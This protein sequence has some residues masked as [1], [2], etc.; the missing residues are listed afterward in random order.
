MDLIVMNMKPN[1]HPVLLRGDCPHYRQPG[2]TLTELMV[3][4]SIIVVLALVVFG[5]ATRIISNAHKAVC[6]QNLHGIGNAIQAYC[7]ENNNRLPGPLNVG[8]SALFNPNATSP[9]PQLVHHIAPYLEGARDADT[10]YLVGNFGCPAL[11]KKMPPSNLTA[12]IVYRMGHDDLADIYGRKGFPWIWNNPAGTSGKPWRLDQI[13][14]SSAGRVYAMIEQDQTLGG[15]WDNNG[16]TGPAH[17]KE[18]M[19]LYFDWSVKPRPI[20]QR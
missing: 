5:S 10:P 15:T 13:N 1:L 12:P 4:I 3:V 8:Q 17:G 18:R 7:M 16:A 6:V 11:M 2:F 20:S 9:G 19:A 14:P